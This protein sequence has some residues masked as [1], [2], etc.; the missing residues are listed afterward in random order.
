MSIITKKIEK[1]NN[2]TLRLT[3]NS[4]LSE[5]FGNIL[6]YPN[7]H[8]ING[9]TYIYYWFIKGFFGTNNSIEYINDIKSRFLITYKEL[10]REIKHYNNETKSYYELKHFQNLKSKTIGIINNTN[11]Y[12][13]SNDFIF[14]CL[15]L[16]SEEVILERGLI[17][18]DTLFE[19]GHVN[20][21]QCDSLKCCKDLST[22]K[23]K[24]RSIVNYY[25][26]R[27][28]QLDRYIKKMTNEELI[29][30]RSKNMKKQMEIIKENNYKK[31]KNFLSGMFVEE[32]KKKNGKWNITKL[33]K[34]LKMS[35]NTIYKN[36]ERIENE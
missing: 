17:D 12:D 13:N 4:C 20:F 14:W 6:P 19:F 31:L 9:D 23:S 32:Y 11:R 34:D 21:G 2:T 5:E 15:K 7:H 1:I 24:C 18:Y 33:S 3:S 36:M 27:D 28:Y 30:S 22:L 8:Y 35:R 29:M 26:Y 10:V 16:Y 25:I